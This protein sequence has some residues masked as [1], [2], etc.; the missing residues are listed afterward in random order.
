[1]SPLPK[2]STRSSGTN[3]RGRRFREN[4]ELLFANAIATFGVLRCNW[5]KAE[6]SDL[7]PKG[8][9][10]KATADHIVPIALGGTHD[11]EN[12]VPA[13]YECNVARGAKDPAEWLNHDVPGSEEW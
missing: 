3:K 12:L 5:C 2:A 13:C 10:R 8:H 1:M 4:R 7:L 11:L 9:P 6:I